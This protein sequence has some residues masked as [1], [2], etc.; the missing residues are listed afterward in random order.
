A[1]AAAAILSVTLVPVLMGYLIRGRIVP[2]RRNPLN[3]ITQWIYRPFL[4]A[5]VAWPW[6]TVLLAAA[7]VGSMWYPAQRLGTEFMPELNEG[8][9]LY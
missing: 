3:V 7:L 1:M 9:F 8:D 6:A 2:E 4:D 5:A